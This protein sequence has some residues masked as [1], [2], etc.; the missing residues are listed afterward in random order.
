MA[1]PGVVI[2][3]NIS[4]YI[5][6]GIVFFLIRYSRGSL[7]LLNKPLQWAS[8]LFGFGAIL[9]VFN[10]PEGYALDSLERSLSVLPN[11]LY[12]SFLIILMV[13]HRNK[14]DLNIVYKS[15][16]W[17]LISLIIYYLFLQRFLTWLP[18]FS[19]QT[20]N[21]F[22]FLM[23][24][25]SPT[26][27][28]YLAK[29]KGE[30]WAFILL[31]I[32]VLILMKEGRRAGMV[33]VLIGGLLSLFAQRI[34]YWQIFIALC[35][36][37]LF[38]FLLYTTSVERLVFNTSERIH[39]MIYETE[40]IQK[41]DLS[42][43]TRI[44]MINKGLAIYEKHPYTGIGLNNFTNIEIDYNKSFEGAELVVYK[45]DMHH[46]SAHNSYI[47]ILAEGGLLQL[48][49]F[50]FMLFS[51]VLKLIFNY[52]SIP[53]HHKPVYFGVLLMSIHL[54]FIMAIVNVFAWYLIGLGCSLI[55]RK[56]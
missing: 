26:A 25:F 49:P 27:L 1:F 43:L 47:G 38:F 20:P 41:E 45:S 53:N 33:L 14:I 2:V 23:I 10:I 31:I 29:T 8:L 35:I 12:W 5:F 17:G 56:Y 3:Q 34:N 46:K 9:S 40:K 44:A 18:V 32:F 54:Y 6:A 48:I 52:N 15:A 24:C 30:K 19:E 50:V 16:F 7:I 39:Q 36:V 4:I 21:S 11:Y 51:I 42:Y 13:T 28:H 37:P 55:Y 22:A